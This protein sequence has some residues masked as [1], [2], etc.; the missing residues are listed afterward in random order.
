M[1]KTHGT[2]L[3]IAYIV[4]L[5][6]RPSTLAKSRLLLVPWSI[7]QLQTHELNSKATMQWTLVRLRKCILQLPLMTQGAELLG[8]HP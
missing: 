1:I 5:A 4:A 2:Q 6:S 8:G 7:C 3:V